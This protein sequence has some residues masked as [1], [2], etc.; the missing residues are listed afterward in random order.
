MKSK[1]TT[2]LAISPAAPVLVLTVSLVAALLALFQWMELVVVR[3]G[4]TTVCNINS[5]VNCE[6][7]WD[8]VLASRVHHFLGL[9][10]AG[11]GLVWGLTAFGLSV[12]LIYRILAGRPPEPAIA[13]VRIM[14][15]AGILACISF[16]IGSARIG[17][18]CPTCLATYAVVVA[19][20]LVVVKLLPGP[21]QPERQD[22]KSALLWSVGLGLGF[23]LLL[24]VPGLRT[25]SSTAG[26]GA[27]E[28]LS[29]ASSQPLG[30]TEKAVQGYFQ[31]L[32]GAELQVV[33]DA[34]ATYRRSS[35]PSF[36]KFPVRNRKGSEGAPVHFVEFTDIKCGHCAQLVEMMKQLERV[37][38]TGRFSMEARNFPLDASCNPAVSVTKTDGLSCLGAKVQICLEGAA[39]FWEMREKL[40]AEQMS[41]NNARILEIASSGLTSRAALD[42]CL[43][44][45]ETQAKLTEDITYAMQY[46][47]KGTPLVLING[48]EAPPLGSFLFAMAMTDGN[49][50]SPAFS[51]LPPP[52]GPQ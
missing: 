24:L 31:E 48:R 14:A 18:I 20:A 15:G 10:V 12:L 36:R 30:S 13:A 45:P 4:G 1:Q 51:R 17:S 40:F 19:F 26:S 47:P 50:N 23:Y 2:T 22:L 7:V 27:L 33:S 6:T 52:R 11:L 46:N 29:Q 49:A 9:P 37:V 34:L 28:K 38:P 5:T 39:D 3:S 25:P 21:L 42:R 32:S 41:L 35:N 8:S 44:S 16:A 43:A